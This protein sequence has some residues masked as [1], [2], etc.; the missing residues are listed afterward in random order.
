MTE[1]ELMLLSCVK[2]YVL[3][4]KNV[5]LYFNA[6]LPMSRM[7]SISSNIFKQSRGA[8]RKCSESIDRILENSL[9]VYECHERYQSLK[10][11]SHPNIAPVTEL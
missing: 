11:K 1:S 5:Y 8:V 4:E 7:Q 6:S 2:N 9:S 10:D 3:R